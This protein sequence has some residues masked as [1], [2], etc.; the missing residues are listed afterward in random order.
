MK[1]FLLILIFYLI[2]FSV[3]A[4]KVKVRIVKEEKEAL[5]DWHVLDEEYNTVF[6]GKDFLKE[7]TVIFGLE[8]NK[9]Y[10]LNISINKAF[11][12]GTILYS[13][14]LEDEPI[15]LINSDLGSG[16][17][18]FPFFT[19]TKARSVKIT[20]G[21][22]TTISEF[23]WQVFLI[24]G[25]F[26]CGG[27]IIN[28][29]WIL[30]AAHCTKNDFGN[31]ILASDMVV[32]VG[33]NNPYSSLEGK[34]YLVSEVIVHEG[35]NDVTNENDIALLKLKDPVNFT[36]AVPVKLV[37]ADDVLEGATSPGVMSWVTGWGLTNVNPKV[38]P[39]S[40]QKVQLPIVTNAVASTVWGTIPATDIMAGYRNGNKDACSG[41]S[42][43][44]MVVPVLGEYKQAGI[45][46][47]GSSNCNSYGGYTRVS[48]FVSWI[49]TNTGIPIDYK[50]PPPAGDQ[51]VCQGEISDVYSIT[52]IPEAT[53]YE[54]RL[55]PSDAG[56]ISGNT[57][58]SSVLWNTGYLGTIDV[59]VRVTINNIV[60]DW[61]KLPVKIV[62]NTKLLSQ[63]GNTV[64][65]AAQPLTLNATAE[66]NN[67]TYNWYQ[68]GILVQKGILS[69]YTILSTKTANSGDYKCEISGSC[70]T[71]VSDIIKL[72][73]L[74]LTNILAVSPD[75][76]VPFGNDITLEVNSAGHNLTYQWEKD[77]ILLEN[78]ITS[79]LFLQSVN[80]TNIGLYQNIVKGTCGTEVS[81]PVY[82][83]VKKY[84]N[85]EATEVFVWPT[86]T[87]S[88]F[89]VAIKND[90]S[91]NVQIY[92]I[93]GRLMK[94]Q[95][96][97]QYQTLIDISTLPK[98]VYIVY[99]SNS[100]FRKS[101]KLMKS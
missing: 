16:N 98:G 18:L 94:E 32:K 69:N 76:E 72:T 97:C 61:S 19:G 22:T 65:C 11:V 3:L 37:S 23:P 17:H 87:N 33:A 34:K 68:N 80:A 43:G 30:T 90:D 10:F 77:G 89:N 5:N 50:P 73:V 56:V 39:N 71:V 75:A 101:V 40:L 6:S 96:N 53:A 14:Q 60:S 31:A 52:R 1:N 15:M 74:P 58:N 83:Y 49:K 82:V 42:G 47:W 12:S 8:A 92:S 25:N 27:S 67:L 9:K 7:D 26:Q 93:M 29:S 59:L 62:Q 100:N 86:M 84:A 13:F 78:N 70:G 88:T 91:Y 44:P 46:S 64:I 21:T 35:Y 28:E 95:I 24:A 48:L 41:D 79:Q 20:G 66:G 85:P 38:F 45:V 54:W 99:V 2:P 63:S 51:I 4:Q 55:Y 36:N 57:E 81:R